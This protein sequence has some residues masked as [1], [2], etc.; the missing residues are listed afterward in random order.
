MN[1]CLRCHGMHFNGAIR[2]LVQ[3]H[4]HQGPWHL[5]RAGL[6]RSAGHSLPGLPPG[7]PRRRAGSQARMRASPWRASRSHDSLAFFDRREACILPRL[8]CP[9]RSCTMAPALVKISQDPRQAICYQ[10]HAPRQPEAG[11]PAAVNG[12]GPQVGSGDDRTPMGVHEGLSCVSC[13]AGHNRKR[14]RILQDLPSADVPLRP[15]RG[16]D[17][18]HLRQRRQ[19]AQHSLG[20]VR[21]LPSARHP[22]SETSCGCRSTIV[23]AVPRRASRKL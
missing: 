17:G 10:C 8:R 7:S 3:P 16:E 11:T 1:D 22:Q 13:H 23:A 9:F 5:I 20:Q 18:H 15:R 4:E 19:R 14:A 6:R 12:W 2:D 21:G